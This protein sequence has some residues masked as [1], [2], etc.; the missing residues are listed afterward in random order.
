MENLS[1][2]VSG[3]ILAR[4]SASPESL[5]RAAKCF[6]ESSTRMGRLFPSDAVAHLLSSPTAALTS[7]NRTLDGASP[8]RAERIA[9][10]A[11]R[12]LPLVQ[13]A[14]AAASPPFRPGER[15]CRIDSRF[16]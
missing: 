15:S 16:C 10:R 2:R 5:S 1:V 8:L 9:A 12:Y 13:S 14:H 4:K 3:N 6:A 11:R 7:E